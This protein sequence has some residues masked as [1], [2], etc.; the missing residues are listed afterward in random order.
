MS[1]Q[2]NV[3]PNAKAPDPIDPGVRIGHAH[4]RTADIDRIGAF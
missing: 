1:D 4:P 2:G 3:V